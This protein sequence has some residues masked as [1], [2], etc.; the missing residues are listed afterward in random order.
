MVNTR[1]KDVA[2]DKQVNQHAGDNKSQSAISCNNERANSSS[3]SINLTPTQPNLNFF[4][5]SISFEHNND[6]L[7]SRE[8]SAA[9]PQLSNPLLSYIVKT[10]ID[11]VAQNEESAPSIGIMLG[12]MIASYNHINNAESKNEVLSE[13]IRRSI[14]P[15]PEPASRKD[16]ESL[17]KPTKTR[18]FSN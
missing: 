6:Y 2:A 11:K 14:F 13:L 17:K 16:K 3:L 1:D 9:D 7:H 15:S 4:Q 18:S 12:A 8:S 5:D 10:A